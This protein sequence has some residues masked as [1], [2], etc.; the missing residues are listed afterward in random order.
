[1]KESLKIKGI[2]DKLELINSGFGS[3][4]RRTCDFRNGRSI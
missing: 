3:L 4:K 2:V 1:M